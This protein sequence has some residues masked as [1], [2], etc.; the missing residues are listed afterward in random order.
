MKKTFKRCAD[1]CL[2]RFPANFAGF[3]VFLWISRDFADLLEIRG[4]ATAWNIRSPKYHRSIAAILW[5][6]VVAVIAIMYPQAINA[7][8]C[9]NHEKI[10]S[11]VSLAFLSYMG[12]GLCLAALRASGALPLECAFCSTLDWSEWSNIGFGCT[13]QLGHSCSKAG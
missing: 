7:A 5:D 6:S 8:R 12:M 4:S 1:K 13:H 3:C 9:D 2:V 11:W 10:N